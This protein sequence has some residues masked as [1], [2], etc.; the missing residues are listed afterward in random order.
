M[1]V[2]G[3]EWDVERGSMF[4]CS[5]QTRDTNLVGQFAAG[6]KGSELADDESIIG[7]LL[8]R[9]DHPALYEFN[10]FVSGELPEIVLVK[11]QRWGG[12]QVGFFDRE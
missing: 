10:N 7:A 5:F 9:R 4:L 11:G 12:C 1:G 2:E 6:K 8:R 3:G